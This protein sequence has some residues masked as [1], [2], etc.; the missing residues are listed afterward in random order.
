MKMLAQPKDSSRGRCEA[1]NP[2]AHGPSGYQPAQAAG[3]ATPERG[4]L[5]LQFSSSPARGHGT[6]PLVN[7]QRAHVGY[8]TVWG[9]GSPSADCLTRR[10]AAVSP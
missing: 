9:V 2:P 8:D 10:W 6:E 4:T 1:E 3:R 7:I 5:G